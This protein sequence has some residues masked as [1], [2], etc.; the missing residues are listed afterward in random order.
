MVAILRWSDPEPGCVQASLC[1]EGGLAL[2]TQLLPQP[3]AVLNCGSELSPEKH[4]G[5]SEEISMQLLTAFSPSVTQI[6][7][8]S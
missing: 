6:C 5:V 7:N 1:C 8:E 2:E 3:L 4:A